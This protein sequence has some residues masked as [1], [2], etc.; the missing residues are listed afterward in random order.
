MLKIMEFHSLMSQPGPALSLHYPLAYVYS[1]KPWVYVDPPWLITA[2]DCSGELYSGILDALTDKPDQFSSWSRFM[3]ICANMQDAE[4]NPGQTCW[5]HSIPW[6]SQLC[7]SLS[8]M[9]ERK[10]VNTNICISCCGFMPRTSSVPLPGGWRKLKMEL[11]K[12]LQVG[13]VINVTQH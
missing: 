11:C 3:S 1:K 7:T 8:Q 9:H 12:K 13:K 6:C 10:G 2:L 4:S 5:S